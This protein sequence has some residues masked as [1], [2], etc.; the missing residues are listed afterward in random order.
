V[1]KRV[2]EGEG[3]FSRIPCFCDE[4]WRSVGMMC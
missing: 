3:E 1:L 2:G 4:G